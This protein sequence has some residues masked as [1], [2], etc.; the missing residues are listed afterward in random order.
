MCGGAIGTSVA[1][2]LKIPSSRL[3]V[4]RRLM[5]SNNAHATQLMRTL[6]CQSSWLGSWL[7]W[8]SIAWETLIYSTVW[9]VLQLPTAYY[10]AYLIGTYWGWTVFQPQSVTTHRDNWRQGYSVLHMILSIWM[11]RTLPAHLIPCR[12]LSQ[13]MLLMLYLIA[14]VFQEDPYPPA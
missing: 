14:Y 5:V 12:D 1:R 8:H 6:L 13:F 9:P 4:S 2:T 11:V 3:A 10:R 7:T